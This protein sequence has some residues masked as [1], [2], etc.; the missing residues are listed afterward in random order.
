[1]IGK[2]DKFFIYFHTV[3]KMPW[4]NSTVWQ[5]SGSLPDCKVSSR[6]NYSDTTKVIKISAQAQE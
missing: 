2:F 3:L 5:L 6:L 4:K 1:M